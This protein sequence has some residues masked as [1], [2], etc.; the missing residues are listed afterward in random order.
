MQVRDT[1]P[2]G[3]L[4]GNCSG[5]SGEGSNGNWTGQAEWVRTL[6]ST[7]FMGSVLCITCSYA[8]LSLSD[9]FGSQ[10]LQYM[11]V[12]YGSYIGFIL[13]LGSAW[14]AMYIA[15]ALPMT[16][17]GWAHGIYSAVGVCAVIP[18]VAF[19]SPY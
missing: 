1:T 4:P 17:Y 5:S 15:H 9:P 10:Q 11:A 14:M 12:R 19:M 16:S 18:I 6:S 3:S 2:G 8:I 13:A 7:A